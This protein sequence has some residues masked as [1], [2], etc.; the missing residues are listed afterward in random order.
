[1]NNSLIAYP[2]IRKSAYFAV[3]DSL[4]DVLGAAEI[5]QFMWAPGETLTLVPWLLNDTRSSVKGRVTLSVVFGG[6]K[7]VLGA[8]QLEAQPLAN[9]K[10]AP[11]SFTIPEN[12]AHKERFTALAQLETEDGGTFVNTYELVI[13]RKRA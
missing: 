10:G 11:L 5:P 6:E 3:R 4:R 7:T 1:V 8:A 9:A 2:E 13:E 12:A